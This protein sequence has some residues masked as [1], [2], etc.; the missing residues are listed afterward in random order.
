MPKPQDEG[1]ANSPIALER[2]VGMAAVCVGA[3]F[4]LYAGVE[5][6]ALKPVLIAAI[7]TLYGMVIYGR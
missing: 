2:N 4:A 3:T 1:G 6:W 5:V 7:A